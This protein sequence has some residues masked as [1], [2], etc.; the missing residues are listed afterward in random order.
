MKIGVDYY[1]EQW[2]RTLWERDIEL[3]A[4]T[5]V[6][7]V[8]IGEFAWSKL[9]P[10]DNKFDFNWLN[11][12]LNLF[13]RFSIGVIMC[14]PTNCPPLW[15]YEEHPEII[16]VGAD[17]NRIQ[18]GIRGHR[19]INSPLFQ[20]Y[21]KR[22]TEQLIRR[23]NNN[24]AVVAWQIDNELEAYPCC[25]DVCK[26]KFREWL[27]DKYDNI[28]N[29]NAAHG[30]S[31]WSGEYF[32]V[33]EIQPPTAYPKAWQN[34]SLCLD[35][36]RFTSDSTA[37]FVRELFLTIRKENMKI[38]ITTNV[39]F[40]EN[41]PDF[42]KLFRTLDF[43]SYDN[44]PPVRLPE[45]KDE[46]YSNAFYLDL[47][48]GIK[49]KNFWVMEQLSGAKGCWTPMSPQPLPGMIKGYALQAIAHGADSVLHFRWRTALTG[50]EMHWHGIFDHNNVPNRRYSEFSELCKIAAKLKPLNDTYISSEI[51]ILY[52]PECEAAFNIQP[53]VEG[54]SYTEQLKLFHSAFM[55]YGAN[56][57]VVS[58]D[59]DISHY[60]LVIAPS[61]YINKR[62]AVENL[63]RYVINGGTLVL[64]ARSG[65]KNENNNCIMDILPTVYKEL[66]GAEITEYD[67]IGTI[68]QT[69]R[70]FA[71]NEF[72]CREWCDQLQL[73][74]ARAYAEY[75]DSYYRCIPAVTMNRYCN[76]VA[77]YVGTVCETD[78]YRSFVSNLMKQTGIPKLTGLPEG[79]EVTTRTNGRDE[80][81]CFF[82]N[83]NES[84][85][86]PLP[87]PMYSIT[88]SV[89][90]DKLE[91]EPFEME[92][93]RK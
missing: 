16:Q 69:I 83:S 26:E 90:K 23:Y 89:G 91:L 4:S 81:I 79:I 25:C 31:V 14:T 93:V 37:N 77:Y 71:G 7:L 41:T 38:P 39:C 22:I 29:I 87:K 64:T 60:K 34:P 56:V 17:G 54:F 76:G 6:K 8:R 62:S 12:V 66:V 92:I 27:I 20:F 21:A 47:M 86:I 3:M 78:F 42:Y 68:K 67:P 65:V 45:N 35:W 1:P 32:N 70:D 88:S 57:D 44:Y 40:S 30:T 72:V 24:P 48:R 52:C 18:T 73:T 74:T 10:R 61:L 53:Q 46:I 28:D 9:E 49:D 19:C 59:T 84:N 15:L 43:V 50:A 55:H 33:S 85:T 75:N 2:D 13:N 58:T 63:Y 5:G 11:E 80:Y 36:Y 51:A 82:N